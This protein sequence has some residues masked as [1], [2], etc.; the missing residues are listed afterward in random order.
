MHY[1]IDLFVSVWIAWAWHGC[2]FA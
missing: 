2:V 1:P